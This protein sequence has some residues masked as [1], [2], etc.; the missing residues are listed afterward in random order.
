MAARG[1]HPWLV[2]LPRRIAVVAVAAAWFAIEA[3]AEPLGMWFWIAAAMAG[4]G[5]WDF[6]ISGTY[7]ERG[8]A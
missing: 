3:W 1:P 8:G 5:V 6:F 7:G 4:Y 2:P